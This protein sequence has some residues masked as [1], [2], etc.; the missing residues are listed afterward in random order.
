MISFKLQQCHINLGLVPASRSTQGWKGWHPPR[1]QCWGL[2]ATS[3]STG[4]VYLTN[5]VR[6]WRGKTLS[7]FLTACTGKMKVTVKGLFLQA[8]F[9][10]LNSK[11][12]YLNLLC[13]IFSQCLVLDV[14]SKVRLQFL[15]PVVFQLFH[16]MTQFCRG[17]AC[18]ASGSQLVLLSVKTVR[19]KWA[20]QPSHLCD[21]SIPG[22]INGTEDALQPCRHGWSWIGKATHSPACAEKTLHGNPALMDLFLWCPSFGWSSYSHRYCTFHT[23]EMSRTALRGQTLRVLRSWSLNGFQVWFEHL[24]A[25]SKPVAPQAC[26]P[27]FNQKKQREMPN[28]F[29]G[30]QTYATLKS[31]VWLTQVTKDEPSR[32]TNLMLYHVPRSN[33]NFG[34]NPPFALDSWTKE[35]FHIFGLFP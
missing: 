35:L 17:T 2:S 29:C 19:S 3:Q 10:H 15:F 11:N 18:L 26:A 31:F 27:C 28:G 30:N 22:I 24:Q 13:H 6:H 12:R 23:S 8:V 21:N 34:S 5:S 32:R 33:W 14:L 9:D 1:K 20:T 7:F 4:I 25:K 16:Q